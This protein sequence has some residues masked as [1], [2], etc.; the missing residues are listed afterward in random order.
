MTMTAYDIMHNLDKE[1]GIP[2]RT[3]EELEI[4]VPSS[5]TCRF[6]NWDWD[7]FKLAL[8]LNDVNAICEARDMWGLPIISLR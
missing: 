7:E 8:E 5:V 6:G 4:D 3:D 2:R 1:A